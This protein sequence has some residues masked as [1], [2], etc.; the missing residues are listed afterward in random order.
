ADPADPPAAVAHPRDR[1]LFESIVGSPGY[2]APEILLR[3]RYGVECDWWSVGVIMYEML[4]GIPPFFAQDP[5]TTCYKITH[6]REYLVYPPDRGVP[7]DAVDLMQ[8]LM[9]DPK[10]RLDFEALKAHRFFEGIDWAHLREME[11]A[12]IPQLANPL[13]TQYFPEIED[14]NVQQR[15]DE[16][17]AVREV[18]PRG[19]MFA[20]YKFHLNK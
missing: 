19:V 5:S 15:L 11:A 12:Y 6:W 1:R 2:I 20:D 14:G 3:Q 7:D 17:N 9:C 16:H 18:D 8:H 13:D 4:Y 10:E